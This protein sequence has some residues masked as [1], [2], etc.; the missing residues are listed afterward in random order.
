MQREFKMT[1]KSAKHITVLH[2]RANNAVRLGYGHIIQVLLC[3]LLI[4]NC[5]RNC[6]KACG[7][8][9]RGYSK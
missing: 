6:L 1:R 2:N 9:S 3:K 8:S 5:L 7:D 4:N